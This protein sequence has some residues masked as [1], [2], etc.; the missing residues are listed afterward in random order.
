MTTGMSGQVDGVDAAQVHRWILRTAPSYHWTTWQ[1][2]DRIR[3]SLESR[4]LAAVWEQAVLDPLCTVAMDHDGG[5]PAAG[6][7]VRPKPME[8][9][10]LGVRTEAVANV[11]AAPDLPDRSERVRALL[12]RVAT[13][14]RDRGTELLV[15]RVAADDVQTLAAAQREGFVVTES[16]TTWLADSALATGPAD[17]PPGVE[18]EV[19]EG[20]VSGVLSADE[21]ARLVEHTSRWGLNHFRADPEL[22][23]S[24]IDQ[25][26]A[27]WVPNIASGSFSDCL[28]VARKDGR[29]LGVHSEI[30]DRAVLD[31][32]GTDVRVCEW[33]VVLE[34]GHGAGKAL[35]AT[36]GRQTYP[37]G[38]H[39]S[40]ETQARNLQTIR[41]IE[42]TGVARP[43]RSSYTLHAWPRRR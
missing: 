22:D 20:D 13:E 43:I 12:R 40:W 25:F 32:T 19:H 27:A 9:E 23:P 26:Y 14:A 24:K 11:V 38:R 39:H 31:L 21:V 15:L 16:T 34:P 8:T 30:S 17:V 7:F 10:L 2:L 33:V 28:F 42:Q 1:G 41:C 36:A 4:M 29:L 3:P 35:V 18:V 6:T 37:G 5:A